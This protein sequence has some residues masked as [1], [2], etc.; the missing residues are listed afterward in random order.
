M[1]TIYEL[2]E[3]AFL[4]YRNQNDYS[5]SNDLPDD[6]ADW[7]AVH[8][9]PFKF[10]QYHGPLKAGNLSSGGSND[11]LEAID[12]FEPDP[13]WNVFGTDKVGTDNFKAVSWLIHD[14]RR[15]LPETIYYAK[16]SCNPIP[17]II[18]ENDRDAI[19][20]KLRWL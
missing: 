8:K 19:H 9:I 13:S 12:D 10:A 1:E 5:N 17:T 2:P 7:L 16:G 15:G 3:N 14:H 18:F 6:L 4:L 11:Y 20:Y